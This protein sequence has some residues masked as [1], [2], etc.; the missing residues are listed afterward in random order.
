MRFFVAALQHLNPVPIAMNVPKVPPPCI[1]TLPTLF[2]NSR[3]LSPYLKYKIKHNKIVKSRQN[4][5]ICTCRKD[6]AR[7]NIFMYFTLISYLN[8]ENPPKS[9]PLAIPTQNPIV[10]PVKNK[11]LI[12]NIL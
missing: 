11:K 8:A 2:T 6:P 10:K 4:C 3:P 5:V 9:A 12:R 7:F 1:I